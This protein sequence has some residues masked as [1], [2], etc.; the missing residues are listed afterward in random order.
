[1]AIR[2]ENSDLFSAATLAEMQDRHPGLDTLTVAGEGHAP[3]LRDAP[4]LE[5]LRA[6]FE[7]CDRSGRTS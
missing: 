1:M 3:L 6:F 7:R 4:T 5:R 2:G